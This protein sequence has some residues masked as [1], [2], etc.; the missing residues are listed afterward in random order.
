MPSAIIRS[1]DSRFKAIY[2]VIMALPKAIGA[3]GFLRMTPASLHNGFPLQGD[4]CR[5]DKGQ[6]QSFAVFAACIMI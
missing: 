4:Y 6:E 3:F 5:L 2:A 1:M